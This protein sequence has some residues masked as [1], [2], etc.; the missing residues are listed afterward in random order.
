MASILICGAGRGRADGRS[1]A[2]TGLG[3]EIGAFT[4]PS[5]LCAPGTCHLICGLLMELGQ[6][7]PCV[8]TALFV[9]G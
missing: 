9:V 5:V 2:A 6:C 7:G 8:L 1:E 3:N 4:T